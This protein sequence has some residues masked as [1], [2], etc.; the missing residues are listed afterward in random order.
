MRLSWLHR[1]GKGKILV[2][3]N[4]WAMD[5]QPFT[6]LHAE[7]YD[8]LVLYGYNHFSLT[9]E[10]RNILAGYPER[11][12]MA[13]SMGV[14]AGQQLFAGCADLFG[15]R[16]AI[17]GTLCPVDEIRG[18]PPALCQG[19]WANWGVDSRV[20]FYRRM[21]Q[22]VDDWQRFSAHLP[23]RQP[24]E[25]KAELAFLLAKVGCL[26]S[27]ASIYQQVC[28]SLA[29]RIITSANQLFYWQ[30]APISRL[31]GGHFPFYAW[32]SWDRI[33]GDLGQGEGEDGR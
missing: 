5:E 28:I 8:V 29:D 26:P 17:N 18:I 4:G 21:F 15:R 7:Q 22:S 20:K 12:L 14:W 25:Q 6:F 13:W 32:Q 1:T 27:I 33:C 9:D 11:V 24:D 30:G 10:L 31:V 16:I 2:F 3:C 23:A 19:T